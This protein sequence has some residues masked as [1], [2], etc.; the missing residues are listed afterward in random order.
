M[1]RRFLL[2]VFFTFCFHF[3][4]SQK[5]TNFWYFGTLAGLD[6]SSGSPVVVTNGTINTNEASASISDSSGNLLF[7]TDGVTVYDRNHTQMPNGDS[8]KGDASTTQMMIV[9]NPGNANLFYIFTL[10]DE[11]G[12]DGLNYSVVDM[13]QQGGNG[14][15]VSKNN[16][17]RS[18]M[19]EKI[20]AVYHCNNHDIWVMTHDANTNNFVAYLVTNS[21][22]STPVISTIGLNHF[23][24]HGQMKFTTDGSKLACAAGYHDTVEVFDFNNR[25]GV[26]SSALS[27]PLFHHVYG[28]EFSP[29]N[30]KLYT[31]YYDLGGPSALVQFDLTAANILSSKV[32][33]GSSPDPNMYSLQLAQDQKIY[34]TKEV[35]PFVSVINNPNAA[36]AAS[37]YL[38]NAINVDPL[39][40][41]NACMLGL[42]GFI[43]SYFNPSFPNI[44]CSNLA[45]SFISSD[46]VIC[47]GV[48]I[49]FSDLS[50]GAITSHAWTFN[51]ANPSSSSSSSPV[52]ICY[53]NPGNY[54]AQ[55]IVSDGTNT[56]TIRETI[57][58][59]PSPTINA[60]P[61]VF[62]QPGDSV[63]LNATGSVITYSW[64]PTG[65]L[66]SSIISNPVAKP[67]VTTT[68]TVVGS[69]SNGC[70]ILDAVT[71]FVEA[72]CGDVFIPNAFSP[73]ED[74]SN[75]FECVLG[76]CILQMYFAIYD[77]WGEKV[78]ET[79]NQEVCWDGTYKGQ[80]MNTATFV[81][82]F[83]AT[84]SS[85][86]VITRK[87]NISL[88]R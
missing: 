18:D 12:P 29:D 31:T 13:S 48:C 54:I 25:T 2:I 76:S 45:A 11:V 41:G 9:P 33:I 66:S 49:D 14:D 60:G 83:N 80:L 26:V 36:G 53:P 62:I 42:P 84:L 67:N 77:R 19:T 55:L 70:F 4:F 32:T 30:S 5:Q 47:K 71:I 85:G 8:L 43:A 10:D 22:I 57:T 40:M 21:G 1:G 86:E 56:D 3:S 46:T 61:D 38:D 65:G 23:D 35:T 24:P 81:Y 34:V 63:V 88:I 15:V 72:P 27:L 20:A 7:Y 68:Y 39:G 73:N 17:L 79:S 59:K 16:F 74:K 44:V 51:G 75:D 50:S 28:L 87:G 64:N 52:N 82:Y 58:V 6:F 78:F 37:N 69:D